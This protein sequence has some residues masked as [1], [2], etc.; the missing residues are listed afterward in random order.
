MATPGIRGSARV[1]SSHA[2]IDFCNPPELVKKYEY[3]Y[4]SGQWSTQEVWVRLSSQPFQEGTLRYIYYLVDLAKPEGQQEHVAKLCKN[5]R[6]PAEHYFRDVMMHGTGKC[7]ADEFN[8]NNPPKK[9][10]FVVP[11]VMEFTMR[12]SLNGR[13]GHLF[14]NVEPFLKGTYK[15]YSNNF[16]FV[17]PDER[18]T[19]HA[20]SHFTYHASGGKMLVCDIQGVDDIYTDPQI[21]SLN[22]LQKWGKG[23]MGAQGVMKFF[24][25]HRCSSICEYLKLPSYNASKGYG[26]RGM[27]SYLPSGASNYV[28]KIHKFLKERHFQGPQLSLG[29]IMAATPKPA[30][31]SPNS[32]STPRGGNVNDQVITRR[33]SESSDS[34]PSSCSN[35]GGQDSGHP[36]HNHAAPVVAGAAVKPM[37]YSGCAPY[38]Q[39]TATGQN[40]VPEPIKNNKSISMPRPVGLLREQPAPACRRSTSAPFVD[41]ITGGFPSGAKTPQKSFADKM[42]QGVSSKTPVAARLISS[43]ATAF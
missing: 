10:D 30:T 7:F 18:N 14:M 17:S 40:A 42:Q 37:G 36:Y 34:H 13:D 11:F 12:K 32:V 24:S 19:P 33:S 8:A 9:V 29:S 43:K 15:K 26:T 35:S 21:H 22:G 20:F 39:P 38:R 2:S 27:G 31:K 5:V 16:G 25:T 41:Q 4:K 3:D 1:S 23:D 6:E 28:P